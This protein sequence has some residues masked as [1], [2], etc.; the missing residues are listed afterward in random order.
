MSTATIPD[1]PLA[2]AD[3]A[4]TDWSAER[5]T[6]GVL[7]VDDDAGVRACLRACLEHSGIP[8]WAAASG[9][10]ALDVCREHGDRISVALLD[11]QMPGLDGP[12]T[13]VRLREVRPGLCSFFMSSDPGRYTVDD[14]LRLGAQQVLAKPFSVVKLLGTLRRLMGRCRD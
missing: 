5:H 2:T 9:R 6:A 11:V 1:A 7:I 12:Q 3:S 4:L 8:V 14:L 10:E 13:L